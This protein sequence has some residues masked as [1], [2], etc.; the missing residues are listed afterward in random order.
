MI[1]MNRLS[2]M[3]QQKKIKCKK[4][5]CLPISKLI[6]QFPGL[7]LI[8]AF[9]EVVLKHLAQTLISGYHLPPPLP[10]PSYS[11]KAP[12]SMKACFACVNKTRQQ[13]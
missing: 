12:L 9:R 10:P 4:Q 2:A 1:N 13:S 6:K 8:Q 5:N 11:S 3:W 7:A